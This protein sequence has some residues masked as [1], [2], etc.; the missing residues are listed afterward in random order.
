[1]C[2]KYR[3][4]PDLQHN[5]KSITIDNFN[6]PSSVEV[7]WLFN[8]NTLICQKYPTKLISV[9]FKCQN[10]EDILSYLSLFSKHEASSKGDNNNMFCHILHSNLQFC[11]NCI[12]ALKWQMTLFFYFFPQIITIKTPVICCRVTIK[13]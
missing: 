9:F 10:I 5:T 6:D 1:M 4:E 12:Y 8:L 11:M 2:N 13:R 3:Y 7:F